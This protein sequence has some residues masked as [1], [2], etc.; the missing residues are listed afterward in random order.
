MLLG[1][2]VRLHPL[3]GIPHLVFHRLTEA[4][5]LS[6]CPLESLLVLIGLVH[7]MLHLFSLSECLALLV[8][9]V[10]FE[11]LDLTISLSLGLIKGLL[12]LVALLSCLSVLLT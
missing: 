11:Q 12:K 9:E 2:L 10:G 5:A 7:G 6:V 1:L 4:L 3:E 8:F